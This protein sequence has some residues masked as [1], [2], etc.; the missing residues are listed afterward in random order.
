ME[1]SILKTLK[2]ILNVEVDDPTYDLDIIVAANSVF[3]TLNQIG[4]GPD[5]GFMIT[6]DT[7]TWTDYFN[8]DSNLDPMQLN[9][10]KTYM[11]FRIKLIFDPPETSYHI[12]AIEK[13]QVELEYRLSYLRETAIYPGVPIEQELIL[14]A[15]S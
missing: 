4:I 10:V 1:D 13:Q 7:E 12:A 2:P 3:S 5:P 15:G 9:M 14:D 8:G 11:Y 6:D